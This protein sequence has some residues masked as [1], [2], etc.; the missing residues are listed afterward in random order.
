MLQA[1]ALPES[2]RCRKRAAECRR[3]AAGLRM[4]DTREQMLRVAARYECMARDAEER[5]IAQGLTHL[6][7]LVSRR[8]RQ[9][10]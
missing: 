7:R 6:G 3:T 9:A 8:H 5:E 4:P 2:Q 1:I 10:A